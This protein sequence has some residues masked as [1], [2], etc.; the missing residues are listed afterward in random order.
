[1]NPYLANISRNQAIS[2]PPPNGT[3]SAHTIDCGVDMELLNADNIRSL[4][5]EWSC[6]RFDSGRPRVSDDILRRMRLVTVEEAWGVLKKH[7]YLFQYEGNWWN[8][9]PDRVLVG[10]AVTAAFVPARP[11]LN[12][13][14]D[15]WGLARNAVGLHNSWMIDT[16]VKD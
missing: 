16:L 15:V 4:T 3:P 5:R 1:M 10:R 8:V 12:A 14:L 13:A 9:H 11:D 6:E 2:N 7:G